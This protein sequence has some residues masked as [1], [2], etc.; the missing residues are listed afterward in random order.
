MFDV[1]KYSPE[2]IASSWGLA[3]M[4]RL[5]F[6][7]APAHKLKNV[8]YALREN[9]SANGDKGAAAWREAAG[10]ERGDGVEN[11]KQVAADADQKEKP[12]AKKE[13]V[14][15]RAGESDDDDEAKEEER[16][17]GQRRAIATTMPQSKMTKLFNRKNNDVLSAT[18][19]KLVQEQVLPSR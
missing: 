12:G 8:P 6:V 16:A 11:G 17:G 18:Y 5:R 13:G 2:G 9:G 7:D 4:P 3:T 19:R 10:D 15:R 14:R 1:S